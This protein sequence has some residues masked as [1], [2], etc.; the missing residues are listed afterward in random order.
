[1]KKRWVALFVLLILLGLGVVF[2]FSQQ[3]GREKRGTK[4]NQEELRIAEKVL[5]SNEAKLMGIPGVVG[6]GMGLTER[7]GEPAIHVYVNTQAT[8]GTIPTAIPKQ[9]DNVP[10]R[11]IETDAIKAR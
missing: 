10:V 5:A 11:T 9:I 3:Y 2:V 6:V 8:G 7:G 4:V 1:M